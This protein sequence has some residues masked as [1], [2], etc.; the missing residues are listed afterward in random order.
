MI[1]RTTLNGN[2]LTPNQFQSDDVFFFN[3]DILQTTFLNSL[4]WNK[5]LL[6]CFK[7]NYVPQ[8]LIDNESA[9]VH[10]LV[11]NNWINDPVYNKLN[12]S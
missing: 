6:I 9:Q 2:F 4:S 1:L 8:S 11:S 12:S 7:F 5:S 3:K 10:L